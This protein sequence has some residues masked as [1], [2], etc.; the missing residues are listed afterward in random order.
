MKEE[1]VV[2]RLNECYMNC[3]GCADACLEED[4]VKMMVECIRLDRIC[5]ATCQATV[6]AVSSNVKADISELIKACVVVCEKCAEE[7]EKHS[8]E[9]C[10]S[11]AQACRRCA[12]ACRQF[13]A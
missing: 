11:C 4:D 3:I 12:E 5:A 10:Q 1:N 7:C 8:A 2:A 6:L 13:V 9:H